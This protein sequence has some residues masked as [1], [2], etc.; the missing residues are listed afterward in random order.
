MNSKLPHIS[1]TYL[2]KQGF[3]FLVESRPTLV[4]ALG[5]PMVCYQKDLWPRLS[6]LVSMVRSFEQINVILGPS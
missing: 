3:E 5:V 4:L 1:L 6:N 2:S